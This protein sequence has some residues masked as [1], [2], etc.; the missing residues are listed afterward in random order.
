MIVTCFGLMMS[1]S[2]DDTLLDQQDALSKKKPTNAQVFEV[3]PNGVDDTEN[4]KNAFADAMDVAPGAIVQLMEGE[5]FIDLIEV[6]EFHGSL[7]GAGKGKT[8]ISTIADVNVDV[9]L[10]QNLDVV[11]LNFV[12]GDVCVKDLT[13]HTPQGPLSEGSINFLYGQLGFCAVT[14]Q[15][16]AE[17]NYINAVVDNVELITQSHIY[18]G[19]LVESGFWNNI[20][21]GV[22]LG[23]IDIS[24]TNSSF[25]GPYWAGYGLP[26]R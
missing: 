10:N 23:D 11:L 20:Q 5:Y 25:S 1:C 6:R 17:N 2:N 4:L 8:I 3:A 9:F 13:I 18:T 7:K 26:V 19:L 21:G 24:I 22:P 15:Y 16:E 12:G 14:A